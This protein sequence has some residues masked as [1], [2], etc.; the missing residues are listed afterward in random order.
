MHQWSGDCP[1]TFLVQEL[2]LE[3]LRSARCLD[4]RTVPPAVTGPP[5]VCAT[6]DGTVRRAKHVDVV[7]EQYLEA[8]KIKP[9]AAV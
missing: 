6:R 8:P 2:S 5:R 9:S 1:P 3:N 4:F 7:T